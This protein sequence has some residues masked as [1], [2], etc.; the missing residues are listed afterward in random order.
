MAVAGAHLNVYYVP[1][2]VFTFIL[3]RDFKK[4]VG[5]VLT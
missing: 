2:D 5:M 4:I 3:K 1:F